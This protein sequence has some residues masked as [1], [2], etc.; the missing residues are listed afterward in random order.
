MAHVSDVTYK[1]NEK[2]IYIY[3][4]HPETINYYKVTKKILKIIYNKTNKVQQKSF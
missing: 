1:R 4:K 3:Y 2:K